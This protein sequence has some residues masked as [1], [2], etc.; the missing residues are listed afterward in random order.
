VATAAKDRATVFGLPAPGQ[1]EEDEDLQLVTTQAFRYPDAS[2]KAPR[3]IP[4][5]SSVTLPRAQLV[6]R[7]DPHG[8]R[9]VAMLLPYLTNKNLPADIKNR[10]PKPDIIL[11][12]P[13]TTR[14]A[15]PPSLLRQGEKTQP[16]W[17]FQF[18][19]NPHPIR[20]GTVL[21]MPRFNMSDEEAMALVN[22]FAAV[23]RQKNPTIGLT[24][25]YLTVEQQSDEFWRKQSQDYRARLKPE[26]LKA[27]EERL[28]PVF[29]QYAQERLAEVKRRLAVAEAG[30]ATIQDP[31]AKKTAEK[32]RDDLKREVQELT[33]QVE[34]KEFQEQLRQEWLDKGLYANEAYRMLASSASPCLTCH[35]VPGLARPNTYPSLGLSHE[36]LRPDWLKRWIANPQRMMVHAEGNHPMPANFDK[37][38]PKAWWADFVGRP[39]QDLALE[40]V[41]AIRDILMNYPKAADMPANR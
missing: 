32:A 37:K 19:R 3:D 13:K 40:Q 5:A 38:N 2:L 9:L 31:E 29:E 17:L 36:R 11:D 6:G 14:M 7:A 16:G 18:L 12:D 1:K 15:L 20:P 26:E 23:D 22:Y 34:K 27:R 24:S 30:L 28:K 8:G 41:T 33:T 10:L 4:A 21:R 25:P 35:Q 39:D